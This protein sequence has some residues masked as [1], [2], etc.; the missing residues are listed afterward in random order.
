MYTMAVMTDWT[1]FP[2]SEDGFNFG[3]ALIQPMP[4]PVVASSGESSG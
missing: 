4:L 3:L 1:G 2:D